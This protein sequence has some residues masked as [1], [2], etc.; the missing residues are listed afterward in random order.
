[1]N[2]TQNFCTFVLKDELFG[3][4]VERVQEVIRYQEMTRVPLVPQAVRGLIN[5]RGQIVTAIDL[6]RRLSMS[7]RPADQLPMNV[8]V[9]TDEGAL[10]MLVDDIG[11]VIEVEDA[12]FEPPPETLKGM[13]RE[14]IQGVH[15][16]H[17]GLM[18]VLDIEKACRT[19]DVEEAVTSPR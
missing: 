7:E 15:K 12:T 5:L 10:S 14:M 4:P 2:N 19:T 13:A 8:V 3:V 17:V 16:L 11:D 18:H 6:R 9:R 1:M